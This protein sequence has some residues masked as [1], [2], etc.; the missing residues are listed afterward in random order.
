MKRLIRF[1]AETRTEE[2]GMMTTDLAEATDGEKLTAGMA[3]IYR[4][5]AQSME[6]PD[7]AWLTP[8]YWT[9]LHTMLTDLGWQEEIS[10]LS[11]LLASPDTVSDHLASLQIE[12]TRLFINAVPHVIAPPYGSVYLSPDGTVYGQ[13]SVRTL[14]FY[15]EH[16]FDL[17]SETE[18][19]DYLGCELEFLATLM[20]RDQPEEE[21]RFLEALF[22]PWFEIFRDRVLLESQ[23]P[24][25]AILV[26]LI[27]FFTS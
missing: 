20:D 3:D 13:N 15:R 18:I 24:Y 14:T 23:Q 10:T 6:Y 26:R 27:D 19:P 25:Y 5:L 17:A 11:S 2:R 12:Y 7:A 8:D 9:F 21:K 22:R 4:F 1:D 16:G